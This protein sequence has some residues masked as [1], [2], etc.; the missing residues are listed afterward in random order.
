MRTLLERAIAI[1][2]LMFLLIIGVLSYTSQSSAA[3]DF[4][5]PNQIVTLSAPLDFV[6][7]GSATP[8]PT[9][10]PTP[11][12]IGNFV[13]DDYD[14][15]GRQDA[16]EPGISGVTVQ[17]WNPSKTQLLAQTV[18]NVNGNYTLVAPFPSSYRIRVILP[19]FMDAF[20]PKNQ[21]GGDDQLDSDINPSG[22]NIGFTDV[23]N[24]ASN[25]ISTTI[26][27]AGIVVFRTPTPTRTPTPINIGNFVWDDYD[28]DGRQDAG[29]PG[30][31]GV[32]VQ[33]WNASKTQLLAQTV[34]N[35]NG[36]YTVIAPL[37]GDYRI[38]VLLPNNMDAFSPKNQAGGDDQLDSDINPSGIN[39]GFTDI[40]NLASNVISTTIHDAG[41]VV[42]RTPTPTRTP[43]PINIGNFVWRDSDADGRQDANEPGLAGVTVQL[44]N[45]IMS[46][47]VG[48][49]V[50]NANGSYT[51]TGP[52]PG[53]YRVRV[54][55]PNNA[56]GFSP[57]DQA[58]GND[59]EDSDI[60]AGGAN[61]GFTDV[62]AIAN[63]VISTTTHDAGVIIPLVLQPMTTLAFTGDNPT[64]NLIATS[65]L[66]AQINPNVCAGFRLTA[67]LDGLPNGAAIFY[68][69]PAEAPD[70]TYQIT[71]LDEARNILATFSTANTTS[72]EGDISQQRIGGSFQLI[73]Q[74]IALRNG[75]VICT[76]ERLIL[77]AAPDS[78]APPDIRQPP[79][80]PTPTPR[81]GR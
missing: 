11:V 64:I 29:E 6:I 42:F 40:F 45:G 76:D 26:H 21:A 43:T 81:R 61:L 48:E 4:A 62:I 77:R 10:T 59:Q 30:I 36:G 16:G 46:T 41:I 71:V 35:A 27:D 23:I 67:P 74:V 34:T 58:G 68:W 65:T 49:T 28:H 50:T 33:L 24:I 60:N 18:T 37:P 69:N 52:H 39:F 73:I 3:E 70:V 22:S 19:N 13:W 15:D 47:M 57:K 75:Q 55:L 32:T 56:T 20:S 1:F 53:N 7:V 63:N 66:P 17:L 44:W 78:G 25:V 54:L 79:V 14:H 38:R 51:L 12:N 72:L 5:P 8:T 31:S 9:R 2:L 80:I